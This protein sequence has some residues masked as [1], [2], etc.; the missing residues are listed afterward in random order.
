MEASSSLLLLHTTIAV[1]IAAESLVAESEVVVESLVLS[2]AGNTTAGVEGLTVEF[3]VNDLVQSCIVSVG[4]TA[5][6]F[7]LV[8]PWVLSSELWSGS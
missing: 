6:S 1:E 7:S 2:S 3:S 8:E 4:T 5:G